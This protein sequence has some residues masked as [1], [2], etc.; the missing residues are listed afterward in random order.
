MTK[1]GARNR[2]GPGKDPNSRTSERQGYTL[3]ALPSEGY[4]GEVPDFPLMTF[5]VYRWEFED[6]RRFQVL[7]AEATE[8]FRE[9]ELEL[10]EQA[11]SYPQACAWSMEPWRWNTIAMWVRTTVVC[12]SS[13]ATAADKGSIHRFA[14]QIGMTPAGL[15]ENGWA[16]ARN[17]VGDKAAEKAAEQREPAEGDEVGQRRQKRL[18]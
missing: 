11:W 13:E 14:D 8:A 18:R 9:R 1:G 5:T 3:T 6:K 2:S 16:I 10:W 12:E 7:D 15:K 17:E 4:D